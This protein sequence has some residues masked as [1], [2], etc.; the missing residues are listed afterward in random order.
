MIGI[1]AAMDVE[2]QAIM[3]LCDFTQE[4]TIGNVAFHYG[5]VEWE[6]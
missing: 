6:K 3:E 1:V 4:K 2:V 5:K